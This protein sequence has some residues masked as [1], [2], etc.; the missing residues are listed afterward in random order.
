VSRS[1]L[2]APLLLTGCFD[3][4]VAVELKRNGASGL[5]F[6]FDV[7]PATVAALKAFAPA[8]VDQLREQI[9]TAGTQLTQSG[10]DD[11][12]HAKVK[13]HK[14]KDALGMT[15]SVAY[16]P[17]RGQ[18]DGDMLWTK[19]LKLVDAGDGLWEL[20]F[21]DDDAGD[22]DDDLAGMI[23]ALGALGGTGEGGGLAAALGGLPP[24][25][26]S[27]SI[28]V[29]GAI[30]AVEPPDGVIAGSTATWTI[31]FPITDTASVERIG[32]RRTVRFRAPKG[33]RFPDALVS[34]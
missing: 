1:L 33:T 26:V 24:V 21:G 32:A 30:V 28:T 34:R 4:D 6:G 16:P 19:D 7:Q 14:G 3:L 8:V 22:R 12:G 27:A 18:G 31:S 29:P 15:T 13:Q 11:G 9:T 10:D 25:T 20:S 23:G 2:L 5:S 17:P